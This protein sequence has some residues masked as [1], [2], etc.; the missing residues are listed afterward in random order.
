[1]V[2][3]K[4][5][6]A[7]ARLYLDDVEMAAASPSTLRL[8]ENDFHD[9]RAELSGFEPIDKHWKPE[10]RDTELTLS[11]EPERLPRGELIVDA[12]AAPGAAAVGVGSDL[13]A[14]RGR[15][16][17]GARGARAREV[18]FRRRGGGRTRGG[19]S[20]PEGAARRRVLRRSAV[21]GGHAVDE[22]VLR[23]GHVPD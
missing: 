5:L 19:R 22:R 3:V 18:L 6:P 14:L 20:H 1:D 12:A 23:A 8:T 7:G 17:A 16:A 10:D 15:R 2:L 21:R 9:I 4:T 11:L 13:R